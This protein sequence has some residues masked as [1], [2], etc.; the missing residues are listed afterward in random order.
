MNGMFKILKKHISNLPDLSKNEFHT[1]ILF[2]DKNNNSITI[3]AV[4]QDFLSPKILS[5]EE[6]YFLTEISETNKNLQNMFKEKYKSYQITNRHIP[7]F[8]FVED[9]I[10]NHAFRLSWLKENK[11]KTLLSYN[12]CEEE[13]KRKIEIIENSEKKIE[14]SFYWPVKNLPSLVNGWEL[15]TIFLWTDFLKNRMLKKVQGTYVKNNHFINVKISIGYA[16]ALNSL[17]IFNIRNGNIHS[18]SKIDKHIIKLVLKIF[19]MKN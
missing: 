11:V 16:S 5:K 4:Y 12:F 6:F 15:K 14:N 8:R 10:R 3:G 17:N 19:K 9:Q 1:K 2:L 13:L 7:K 18:C